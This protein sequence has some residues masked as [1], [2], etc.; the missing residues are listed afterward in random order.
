MPWASRRVE[1]KASKISGGA[2]ALHDPG[3]IGSGPTVAD[4]TTFA[5]ALA[6]VSGNTRDDL[7]RLAGVPAERI[8]VVH[9][10]MSVPDGKEPDARPHAASPAGSMVAEVRCQVCGTVPCDTAEE[11][12]KRAAQHTKV[13]GHPTTAEARVVP[14]RPRAGRGSYAP[15]DGAA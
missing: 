10:A 8:Q 13:T 12:D 5:D 15:P 7:V 2:F 1:T 9:H 11:A 6:A 14:L 4:R 3:V